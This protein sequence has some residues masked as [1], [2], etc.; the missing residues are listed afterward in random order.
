A[1]V[2]AAVDIVDVIG[3]YLELKPAGSR[4]KAL[5][6]FH[7]EK[8]PSFVVSRDRQMYHCFGC[9]KGGDA[10]SFLMEYEGLSF[11]EGLRKLADRG[12]VRLPAFKE[13]DPRSD[14]LR[15][16]T[17]ELCRFAEHYFRETLGNPLQ[18]SR[19][20]HYL[21]TRQLKSATA[22]RFGLGYAP[23]GWSSLLD[24][25]RKK[26]F[27]QDIIEA[28]GLFKHGDRGSW[29]DA[30]RDRLMF[31]IRD[32]TGNT[33][34]FGGRALESGEAKYINSP[35]T[36]IY[37]KSRVLYGLHEAR[38]AL[39]RESRALLVEGYMDLLRCFD[40]GIEHVVATCGT[41][42]TS[43]QAALMRRYV[44]EVV[45]VY[46][47]D[48]AGIQA[49]L[50][51]IGVL[52]AAGLQVRATAL[53]SGQ[54][55]DD[56]IREAG[57]EAFLGRI[58]EAPDFVTFF[59]RMNENRLRTIEGKSAVARDLFAVLRYI[60][61]QLRLDEYLKRGAREL[62]LN[63]WSFRG[64]FERSRRT[65]DRP[66]PVQKTDPAFRPRKDDVD[67]IAALLHSEPL[68]DQVRE[69]L[70]S[71][72][73]EGDPVRDVLARILKTEAG[74]EELGHV[75]GNSMAGVLYS[76]AATSEP[77]RGAS[78]ESIVK[79]RITGIQKNA[80][81]A[82]AEA[83]QAAIREAERAHDQDRVMA[84]LEEKVG[85]E[86]ELRDKMGAA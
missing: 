18:G 74:F 80:L 84:L 14:L 51:G 36:L 1:E 13:A 57:P 81:T 29:Y 53:P 55:P 16:R 85:V 28:S 21:Q 39:R 86:R 33:V 35:E 26:P 6:P 41:A 67:F 77:P 2:L 70:Q 38:E 64:E 23:Q 69:A 61:D 3:G 83:L 60:E 4:F 15:T 19:G 12:G 54:D 11:I 63:E 59:V 24:A 72:P 40:A 31:P 48:A 65:S 73:L 76:A 27:A 50:R 43:E 34:A 10:L 46:D 49:A 9:G 44:P 7:T 56:F 75:L 17:L 82:R 37:K 8:T 32:V 42:L 25:A 62:G 79:G 22:E 30:F 47:G 45:V 5:C 71:I 68:R 66:A 52:V 58:E 20:R 78:A